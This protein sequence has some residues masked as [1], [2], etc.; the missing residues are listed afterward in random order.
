MGNRA[1]IAFQNAEGIAPFGVYLHWNGGPESVRAFVDAAAEVG[2]RGAED[3][4]YCAARLCQIIGNY[5]GGG[6]SVGIVTI[7]PAD[8][9]EADQG[10]NGIYILDHQGKLTQKR[11]KES[12]FTIA[13]VPKS[14]R[15]KYESIKAACIASFVRESYARHKAQEAGETEFASWH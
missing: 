11:R 6:L 4:G 12:D 10:D 1:V 13:R 9:W 2:M 8:P 3:P 15:P 14:E 5:F 7:N